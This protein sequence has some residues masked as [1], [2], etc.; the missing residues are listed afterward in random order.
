MIKKVLSSAI[1]WMQIQTT[2]LYGTIRQRQ[3][4]CLAYK[5]PTFQCHE[6]ETHSYTRRM[7]LPSLF[8]SRIMM[9]TL[10]SAVALEIEIH[11]CLSPLKNGRVKVL[12]FN[13]SA[14]ILLPLSHICE[15]LRHAW[16]LLTNTSICRHLNCHLLSRH[17]SFTQCIHNFFGVLYT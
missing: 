3:E 15:I 6:R 16:D 10:H 2:V 11:F 14:V 9:A 17:S 5:Q 4:R 1:I 13:I 7:S 8:H 12:N